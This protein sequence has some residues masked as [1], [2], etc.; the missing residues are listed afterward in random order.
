MD[1]SVKLIPHVVC[2]DGL[3]ALEVYKAAFGGEIVATMLSSSGKLMH[4]SVNVM[5]HLIYVVEEFP[6]FGSF[7]PLSLNGT[8]VT[9][10]LHVPDCDAV[11]AKAI[12]A[13]FEVIMP[14]ADMFWGD[15][16]GQ[17]RDPF[18]HRWAI[19]TTIKDVSMEEAAEIA[20][21]AF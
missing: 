16:Y 13:G 12:E 1:N 18:G 21:T 3:K 8:S 15:R 11:F 6:D 17:L 10:H 9:L 19:A 2:K 4:G 5:G 20:K 7:S 14:P